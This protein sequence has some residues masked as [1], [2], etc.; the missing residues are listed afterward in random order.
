MP[1]L[2][3]YEV[4]WLAR[5]DTLQTREGDNSFCEFKV[6]KPPINIVFF[7]YR[8]FNNGTYPIVFSINSYVSVYSPR[9]TS[10]VHMFTVLGCPPPRLKPRGFVNILK[11]QNK[12][13]FCANCRWPIKLTELKSCFKRQSQ[14]NNAESMYKS[15][16][17]S[18][19]NK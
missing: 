1:D 10:A 6:G 12:A 11:R 4:L 13:R 17:I 2:W 5:Q 16:L 7:I 8:V 9:C 18:R 15:I 19:S 3:R 14:L